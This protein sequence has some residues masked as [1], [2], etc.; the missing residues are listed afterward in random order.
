MSEK[1]K[2]E[3]T[4]KVVKKITIDKVYL[5]GQEITLTDEKTIKNLKN[6]NYIK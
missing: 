3:Q 2:K 5:A 6:L 4:F 1:K